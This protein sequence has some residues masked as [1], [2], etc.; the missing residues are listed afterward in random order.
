MNTVH[1]DIAK[2]LE[3]ERDKLREALDVA[4]ESLKNA[5]GGYD[6][7]EDSHKYNTVCPVCD[8]TETMIKIEKILCRS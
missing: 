4:L 5:A 3:D 1:I 2:E 7:R 8:A 6:C